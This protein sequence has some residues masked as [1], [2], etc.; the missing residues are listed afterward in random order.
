MPAPPRDSRPGPALH[1]RVATPA[2]GALRRAGRGVGALAR[3][4]YEFQAEYRVEMEMLL[5]R[6]GRTVARLAALTGRCVRSAVRLSRRRVRRAL[7]RLVGSTIGVMHDLQEKLDEL[8]AAEGEEEEESANLVG[9]VAAVNSPTIATKPPTGTFAPA[10]TSG[11]S[12]STTTVVPSAPTWLSSSTSSSSRRSNA[13]PV[14]AMSSSG[15]GPRTHVTAKKQRRTKAVAGTGSSSSITMEQL[16]VTSGRGGRGDRA[17]GG[18]TDVQSVPTPSLLGGLYSKLLTG[19]F[20]VAGGVLI[21]YFWNDWRD[22]RTSASSRNNG[23]VEVRVT[24]D[25]GGTGGVGG[26]A[27]TTVAVVEQD[28]FYPETGSAAMGTGVNPVTPLPMRY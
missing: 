20:F 3:S 2:S 15:T 1:E 10:S 6:T 5:D 17:R 11:S 8:A 28:V 26:G 12:S 7:R 9:D 23:F 27:A 24:D 19:L 16:A 21:G 13:A 14:V 25:N 4:A 22:V 18:G